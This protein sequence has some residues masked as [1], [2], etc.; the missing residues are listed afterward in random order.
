[1]LRKLA[2][3]VAV[4]VPVLAGCSDTGAEGEA[5]APTPA[6]DVT[7]ADGWLGR[8]G[9]DPENISIAVDDGNGRTVDRRVDDQQP[10][11]SAVKV[12]PLAAYARAVATGVLDPQE[13][14]PVTE[15]ERWYFPGSDGGAHEQARSRLPGD[16]VTLDR[17]VSAMIR[18]SDNAVPDYLRDRL[19]DSALV[20]AA[21][22]G[23]W[24]DYQPSSKLG[25]AIRL[26]EPDVA[27]V[28]AAARRYAADPEYREAV[29]SKPVPPYE[30]QAS[31]A[32]TTPT[33]SARQLTSMHRSIAT[34]G[35]GPGSDIARAHLEW[36]PAPPGLVAIGF[37]G[38]S[39]PGILADAFYL[40]R[41][42]GTVATA[43]LLNRRMPADIWMTATQHPA[44]QGLLVRAM[45]EPE[46]VQRLACAA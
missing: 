18:E 24:H 44:E 34:G 16:T 46:M 25:D 2:V 35:F 37:K 14:V 33:A 15:W 8:I 40:R 9:Q 31:W 13:R 22:A 17:M 1:M 29:L 5:C 3:V 12:V 45:T 19:G 26:V 20:A 30:A 36:Q 27:D 4:S 21:E 42:D 43:V 38:G 39:Y 28:W 7:T 41:A 6:A 11:A 10:I 23:G 32:D